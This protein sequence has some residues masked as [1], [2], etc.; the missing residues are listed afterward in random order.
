MARRE[1]KRRPPPRLAGAYEVA[2]YL[3]IGRS[4]LADRRRRHRFPEPLAQL[5]CGPVWDLDD[6]EAYAEER[7]R[8]PFAAYLWSNQPGRWQQHW[9]RQAARRRSYY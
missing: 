8:D 3:G 1:P 5:A 9:D 6:I 2:A 4:A 7:R